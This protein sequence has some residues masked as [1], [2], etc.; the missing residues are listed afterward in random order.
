MTLRFIAFFS[1]LYLA[2]C[3]STNPALPI[4]KIESE[5]AVAIHQKNSS[6]FIYLHQNDTLNL[7]VT[8][9]YR[10]G[11]SLRYPKKS[12][13]VE[14]NEK[15]SLAGLPK[16]DDWVL[17]ASYVDKTFIRHKLGY[18]LFT[19]MNPNNRAPKSTYVEVYENDQYKGLFLF[20]QKLT[21]KTL[22]IKKKDSNAYVFKEP[23]VLYVKEIYLEDTVNIYQQKFPKYKMKDETEVM[24]EFREFLLKA[25]DQEFEQNISKWMDFDNILDW[26]ILILFANAG[27]NINKNLYLYKIDNKTPFR[28]ALWD[29][30]HSFGRD[31]DNEKNL[32]ERPLGLSSSLLF[33]RLRDH[34]RLLFNEKI[35][36]RWLELRRKNIFSY[37]SIN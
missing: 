22:G 33:T 1:F 17:N 7:K 4:I 34:E 12:Y 25:N 2:A 21:A 32:M 23:T 10:G 16:E 24:M 37:S 27:D 13:A 19:S 9:K 20:M 6:K 18:D 29:F 36:D 28:V 3:N 26:Y 15:V 5:N 11:Y 35:K 30:D 31:G 14:L 8:V